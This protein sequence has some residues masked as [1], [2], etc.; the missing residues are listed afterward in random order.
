[1]KNF[2]LGTSIKK[3]K[4]RVAKI[5]GLFESCLSRIHQ[6]KKN[7]NNVVTTQLF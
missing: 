7:E 5:D 3:S 6:R 2:Y 4:R 1:M